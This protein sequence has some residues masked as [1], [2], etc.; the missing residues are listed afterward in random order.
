MLKCVNSEPLPHLLLP[1]VAKLKET[2]EEI[3][4][5][6]LNFKEKQRMV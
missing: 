2:M 3:E 4:G 6:M 1:D 5:A